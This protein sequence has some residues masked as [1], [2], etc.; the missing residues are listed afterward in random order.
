[1]ALEHTVYRVAV[2]DG[3]DVG[4]LQRS[5]SN[6]PPG[7]DVLFDRSPKSFGSSE[8]TELADFL[9]DYDGAVVRSATEIKGALSH[10]HHLKFIGRA[11]T[12]VDNIDRRLLEQNGTALFY[13]PDSNSVPVAELDFAQIGMYARRIHEQD[14]RLHKGEHPKAIKGEYTGEELFGK[15]CALIGPGNIGIKALVLGTAYGMLFNIVD[16]YQT[17]DQIES[18][19]LMEARKRGITGLDFS[20]FKYQKLEDAVSNADYTVVHVS[21]DNNSGLVSSGLVDRMKQGAVLVNNARGEIIDPV[22]VL[23]ALD[24]GKLSAYLTDFAENEAVRSHPKVIC[25]SHIGGSTTESLKN[26]A[27]MIGESIMAF[28]AS[29]GKN[30]VRAVN[31]SKV[32]TPLSNT[33]QSYGFF[34]SYEEFLEHIDLNGGMIP[35]KTN[36]KYL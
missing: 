33:P 36:E 17:K 34:G 5:V 20:R 11:G 12:G 27:N 13:A 28:A 6:L 10:L 22:A 24:S 1:M 8:Q 29:G 7:I 31:G 9:K 19:L 25:T 3:V 26:A 16:P 15:T 14:A 4:H 30:L 32:Q 18:R 2:F 23:Q 35:P 21:S